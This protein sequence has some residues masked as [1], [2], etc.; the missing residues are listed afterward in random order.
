MIEEVTKALAARCSVNGKVSVDKM[1]ENQLVQYQIAWLT[2]EQRI[3]EKFIEY[4]WDSSRGTGDLEQEMA[5][6]FAAETVNHIRSEISSRP[7]EYGIKSSDLVSKIFNDEI[8]QFL[9]NAMAIKTIMRSRRRS[10]R[11][12]ISELTVWMKITKCFVRLLRSLQ[13]T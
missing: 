10:L 11:K 9:E 4:A 2:S 12:D 5:V 8:N 6:V 3:A 13:K 1:D 7:S